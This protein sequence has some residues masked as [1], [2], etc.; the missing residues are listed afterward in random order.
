MNQIIN[1]PIAHFIYG[2]FWFSIGIIY[3]QTELLTNLGFGM[4][5]IFISGIHLMIGFILLFGNYDYIIHSSVR[6][7][8]KKDM[9]ELE[10]DRIKFNKMMQ[11]SNKSGIKD[12]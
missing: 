7:Q 11:H 9:I 3:W 4:I 12:A 2:W 6:Q 1:H 10:N 8:Y 5:G